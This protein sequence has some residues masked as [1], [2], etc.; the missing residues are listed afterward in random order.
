MLTEESLKRTYERNYQIMGARA[1]GLLQTLLPFQKS[2]RLILQEGKLDVDFGRGG[3]YRGDALKFSLL[4]VQAFERHPTRLFPDFDFGSDSF[5]TDGSLI[6]HR[7]AGEL[8]KKLRGSFKLLPLEES[9]HIPLLV[10]AGL[11]FGFHLRALLERY[12]VQNL[13]ILDVPAFFALSL[14][15]LDWGLVFDYYSKPGRSLHL[16]VDDKLLLEENKD[17]AF[18]EVL[19][20]A[21]RINPG[22]FYWGYYLEHLQYT[23]TLGFTEWLQ[24]SP[25]FAELFLGYFDD[26]LWSL[27]WTLERCRGKYLSTF[28]RKRSRRARWP[29]CWEQVLLLTRP[30]RR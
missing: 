18:E 28:L 21:Q 5:S 19:R 30:W 27:R 2:Y 16:I 26:E 14:H 11:G 15:T 24:S 10:L 23:P 17:K 25:L 6:S 8:H 13:I 3:I 9:R 12:E 20:V 4:Q 29:S 7:Y 1:P 22:L